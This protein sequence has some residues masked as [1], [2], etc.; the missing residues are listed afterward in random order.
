MKTPEI[1]LLFLYVTALF[2]SC[3]GHESWPPETSGPNLPVRYCDI[4]KGDKDKTLI[5]YVFVDTMAVNW[6]LPNLMKESHLYSPNI[7]DL[8]KAEHILQKEYPSIL[9]K[10][11]YDKEGYLFQEGGLRNYARQYAFLKNPEGVKYVFVNFVLLKCADLEDKE[12]PVYDRNDSTMPPPP[13][14]LLNP[15]SRAFQFVMDGGDAYWHAMLD[16]DNEKVLWVSV[17]GHA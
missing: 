17:N 6:M 9:E 14:P 1:F 2:T 11:A 12:P 8:R 7:S 16:L 4:H 15:M 5:G 10:W 13:P 3:G